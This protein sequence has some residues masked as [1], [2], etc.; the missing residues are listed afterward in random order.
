MISR[1]VRIQLLAFGVITVLGVGYAGADY[2]GLGNQVFEPGY[3]V[4]ADFPETG[5]IFT[6]AEVTYRGV[7][8]GRVGAIHL[9][10]NG[11]LVDLNL[12]HGTQIPVNALA[13]VADRS[14]VGEQYV[15]LQ[16]TSN[17]GPY[18]SGGSTIARA[19][20][21]IP[22]PTTTLMVN[23]DRLVN[24]VNK[25]DLTITIDELG[26]AFNGTGPDLQRLIDSGNA[27]IKTAYD[28]LPQTTALIQ[29]SGTILRTQVDEGSAIAGFSRDLA[30]LTGQIRD[31]D[32]DLRTVLDSGVTAANQLQNLLETTQPTLGVL[33]G[34]LV[35]TGQVVEARLP[36]VEQ[37]LV[38]YPVAVAAGYTVAPGDGT[39]HFGLVLNVN[40]PPPCTYDTVQ[41]V[42]QD[43]SPRAPN[44]DV[45]CNAPRGSATDVRGAQN[46]PAPGGPTAAENSGAYALSSMMTG[47]DPATG[48]ALGPDGQPITIA[49]NGGEATLLG[50]DSWQ[51]ML[52]GPMA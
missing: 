42:P 2:V 12:N 50:K 6:N 36:G 35:S 49:A 11:V 31:S 9:E 24:S 18:L 30:A 45:Q 7:P 29:Q 52:L 33:L 43:T 1:V 22:L 41:R 34:N 32:P 27:L 3:T 17:S 20:T 10:A 16:P 8:V 47:T 4:R 44:T 46:V 21:R 23:L 51:W 26:N 5:G 19:Q 28:N 25:N 40:N 14:A 39:A 13:V 37:I 38:T 15:D 48:A